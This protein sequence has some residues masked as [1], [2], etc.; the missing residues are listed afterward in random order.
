M[1]HVLKKWNKKW[2]S[3]QL[4]FLFAD[5]PNPVQEFFS[6]LEINGAKKNWNNIDVGIYRFEYSI[7]FFHTKTNTQYDFV[8]TNSNVKKFIQIYYISN[9]TGRKHY[10][11]KNFYDIFRKTENIPSN[12]DIMLGDILD[13]FSF[14]QLVDEFV[15]ERTSEQISIQTDAF[16][17][18]TFQEVIFDSNS[19]NYYFVFD[20]GLKIP[21]HQDSEITF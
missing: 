12:I 16:Q 21:L 17:K 8:R 6:H 1:S 19:G 18:R 13:S 11:N 10:M 20:N 4:K 5:L 14:H 9:E 3:F 2:K 15:R 7:S